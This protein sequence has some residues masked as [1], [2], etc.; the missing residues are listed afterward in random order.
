MSTCLQGGPARQT[1]PTH[2]TQASDVVNKTQFDSDLLGC[3]CVDLPL[4]LN[5]RTSS[6]CLGLSFYLSSPQSV[7]T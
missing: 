5:S 7:P 2:Q 3:V 4:I 1:V 6:L